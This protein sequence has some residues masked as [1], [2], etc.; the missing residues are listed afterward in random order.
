MAERIEPAARVYAGALYA[1]A[2]DA[3]RTREVDADLQ[4]L[5]ADLSGNRPLLMALAKP[6]IPRDA[7]AYLCGPVAFMEEMSAA[8]AALG[9]DATH[10]QTEPFGPAPGLTPGIASTPAR[11]PHPPRGEPGAGVLGVPA[12]SET[13]IIDDGL[14]D[15]NSLAPNNRSGPIVGRA[16]ASDDIRVVRRTTTQP[17][18]SIKAQQPRKAAHVS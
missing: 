17:V 13:G 18:R 5:L 11:T 9:L 3:G 15:L 8:L 10:I 12:R 4:N 6:A 2:R 16:L 14:A 1:A 7:E